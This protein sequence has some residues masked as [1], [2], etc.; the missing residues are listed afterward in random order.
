MKTRIIHLF[1][2][3]LSFLAACKTQQSN[4]STSPCSQ[5]GTYVDMQGLDGCTFLIQL[6]D[7]RKLLPIY[8]REPDFQ[9][10]DGMKVRLDFK[11]ADDMASVCM[12]E[13]LIA[14]ITCLERM[15]E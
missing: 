7:G 5:L 14:E 3:C 12:A 2:L 6:E 4:G 11:P 8:S 13:D 10:K 9:P 15:K 1:V